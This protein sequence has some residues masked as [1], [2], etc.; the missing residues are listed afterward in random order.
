MA[1]GQNQPRF[2]VWWDEKE[3]IVRILATGDQTEEIAREMVAQERQLISSL[4]GKGIEVINVLCDVTGAG[5]ASSTG[6]KI[7]VDWIKEGKVNKFAL[8]GGRILTNTTANFVFFFAGFKDVKFFTSEEKALK[9][10]KEM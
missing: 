5:T 4:N 10:L 7:F 2:K 8:C 9:W 1:E 6:R 3:E